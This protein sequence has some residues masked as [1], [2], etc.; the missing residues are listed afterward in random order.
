MP[1]PVGDSKLLLD[2]GCNWGRWCIAA[3]RKG[4]RAF[5]IDPSLGAILAARR[6]S[7][8]ANIAAHFVVADARYLPFRHGMFDVV[9]SYSVL[10]HFSR[11]NAAMALHETARV[12]KNQGKSLIQMANTFGVRC[13]YQQLRRGFRK[14][15]GFEVRY[16]TPSELKRVFGGIIGGTVLSVDGYFALGVQAADRSLL[17][18]KYRLVVDC[19]EVLRRVGRVIRPITLMADSLWVESVRTAR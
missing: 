15:R 11:D 12:L 17:P 10:Q 14:P 19:S 18:A 16:W 2:I 9:F 7:R 4:Y 6:A 1:L 13:L 3:G 5:G 8:D